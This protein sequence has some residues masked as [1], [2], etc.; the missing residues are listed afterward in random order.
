MDRH[1]RSA[2][3]AENSASPNARLDEPSRSLE[4]D[5]G[6]PITR[7]GEPSRS[8]E[9][10][11]GSLSA[12]LDEA[13][14]SPEEDSSFQSARLHESSRSTNRRIHGYP[15]VADGHSRVL[16]LG[17]M[18]SVRSLETGFYYGHKQNAFWRILSDTFSEPL[19][20]TVDEKISLL[21]RNRVALWDVIE[22]CERDGSLDSAIR[23]ATVNDFQ[24]FFES[25]PGIRA[26]LING[27]TAY[28]LFPAR[29]ADK[30]EIL[31]LPSTS[32]AYTLPYDQKLATW[33][34]ALERFLPLHPNKARD[35]E[36][37]SFSTSLYDQ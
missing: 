14:R 28:S 37:D 21:L 11:T 26:V 22:S 31:R 9:E 5:N 1:T 35:T 18:P 15:P 17:S 12:S 20:A 33:K 34:N 27:G 32:P 3:P 16:I 7:L 24:P 25:H 8:P 19:P 10:D 30:R 23:G 29:L 36:L 6:S 2:P 13:C 4:E